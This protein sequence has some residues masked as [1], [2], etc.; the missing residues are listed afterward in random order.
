[1]AV[2]LRQE[3]SD[4]V[5]AVQDDG[6]GIAREELHRIFDPFFRASRADRVAAGSGLGLAICRGLVQAM[7]GRIA[8]ESPVLPQGRGTRMILRFPTT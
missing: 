1:V 2:L 4:A 6:P 8:V 5:I 7:G 3:G